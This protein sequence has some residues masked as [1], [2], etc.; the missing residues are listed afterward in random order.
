MSSNSNGIID[1]DSLKYGDIISTIKQEGL[2]ICIEQR[3]A[4]KQS[5]NKRKAKYETGNLC[6]QYGILPM[7]PS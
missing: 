6:K 1:Y 2:K 7:A 4:K 5:D 3:I